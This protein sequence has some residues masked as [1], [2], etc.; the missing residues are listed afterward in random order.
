MAAG[1]TSVALGT[2]LVVGGCGFVGFHIVRLLLQEPEV[3]SIYVLSRN[4][5]KNLQ[6][7]VNY[8]AGN[9]T[10]TESIRALLDDIKPQIII[11][12][13]SPVA[14]DSSASLKQFRDTNVKGT[15]VLLICAS[16][17]PSVK[18]F[19][20]TSSVSVYEGIQHLNIDE[21]YPL[22]SPNGKGVPYNIS[23]AIADKCVREYN[24]SRLRTIS[25]RLALVYG[26]RDSQF[27]PGAL[28][29]YYKKQ[30]N[31]QIGNNTNLLD[32]VHVNNAASAHILAAKVLLNLDSCAERV[33]GEAFN[34]SDGAPVPYW[35]F[36]RSIWHAAGDK[37]QLQDIKTIPA[38]L[39]LAVADV[40]EWLYWFFTLN[41]KKSR[42]LNRYT[43]EFCINTYVYKVGK[44]N[45]RLGYSPVVDREGG[46]QQ[47]VN[48][49][50]QKRA[51]TAKQKGK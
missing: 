29:A 39:A 21:N 17:A 51:E 11:H 10:D 37:T 18:A 14:T 44:A 27:V 30:T 15:E 24:T 31:V 32:T 33:D 9:I 1:S 12:T 49:E 40:T 6:D 28:E 43:V 34:I 25:L 26:E 35:D 22:C 8:R 4:P 7:G 13:A 45:K 3:G 48:W 23:K 20:Y 50:F 2:I 36:V 42:T 46:I 19:I 47:A 5:T 38:W 16:D 41:Q